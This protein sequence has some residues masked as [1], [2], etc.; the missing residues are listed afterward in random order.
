LEKPKILKDLIERDFGVITGRLVS[1]IVEMCAPNILRG[2]L[3]TYCIDPDGSE[4]FPQLIKRAK[5]LLK[6]LQK[7]HPIGN[8][9][10]VTHGDFGKMLYTAF[11]NLDWRDV[12][13]G[14]H[15]GNSDLL[16]L[17]N[18]IKA[19]DAHVVELKQYNH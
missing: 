15:F 1:K 19:E 18:D 7:K 11:Y 12:L 16:K 4:T 5:K 13:M 8:I 14:F 10:L 9:L 2:E 17:S 6:K 3:V